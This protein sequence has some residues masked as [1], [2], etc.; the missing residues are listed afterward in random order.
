M[1]AREHVKKY[2]DEVD[3]DFHLVDRNWLRE[4]LGKV[5]LADVRMPSD[6]SECHIPGATNIPLK[7]LARYVEEFPREKDIVFYCTS[8]AMSAQA[9]VLMRLMGYRAYALLEGIKGW[10]A[11]GFPVEGE[12]RTPE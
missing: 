3:F 5:Y 8:G 10:K 2:L 9:V 4:R 7:K 11:A 6:F 1:E 12:R